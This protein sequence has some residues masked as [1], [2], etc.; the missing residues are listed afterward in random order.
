MSFEPTL[1]LSTDIDGGG[2]RVSSTSL[3][4]SLAK[5]FDSYETRWQSAFHPCGT[6]FYD[7]NDTKVDTIS[8]MTQQ[9]GSNKVAYIH[10]FD[11]TGDTSTYSS[12]IK[13]PRNIVKHYDTRD[14]EYSLPR[15]ISETYDTYT[16]LV[17][18]CYHHGVLEPPNRPYDIMVVI[19][20]HEQLCQVGGNST[21]AQK[22]D[23]MRRHGSAYRIPWFVFTPHIVDL[24]HPIMSSDWYAAFGRT[25]I[26]RALSA[27]GENCKGERPLY[28]MT[29]VVHTS[30]DGCVAGYDPTPK[31]N[32]TERERRHTVATRNAQYRDFLREVQTA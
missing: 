24:A 14:S 13:D 27:T 2:Y 19:A 8:R 1:N 17:T 10:V 28:H 30:W 31:L 15:V 29:S 21:V 3:S 18:S 11:Y 5:T 6:V 16:S 26:S 22:Y 25:N 20:S 23:V 7:D 4:L 32:T 9:V 12:R